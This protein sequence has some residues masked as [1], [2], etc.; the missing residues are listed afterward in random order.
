[1]SGHQNQHKTGYI[2][3]TQHKPSVRVMKN[4]TKLYLA[5]MAM[6]NSKARVHKI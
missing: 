1:M 4:I 6:H 5:P 2:N 3:Q